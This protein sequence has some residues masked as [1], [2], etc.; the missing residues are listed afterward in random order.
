[1]AQLPSLPILKKSDILM[2]PEAFRHISMEP[3]LIQHTS[4]T[5]G[6]ILHVHRSKEE[7]AAIESFFSKSD[8]PT[9]KTTPVIISI[10]GSTTDAIQTPAP[11]VGQV[12]RLNL[13]DPTWRSRIQDVVRAP[14]EYVEGTHHARPAVIVGLESDLRVLTA[15]LRECSFDFS[16]ASISS[17]ITSGDVITRRLRRYYESTWRAPLFDQYGLSEIFGSCNQCGV[18]GHLH[19]DPHVIMEVVNPISSEPVSDGV[20]I[21]VFTTLAPFVQCQ[22]FI[23]YWSGDLVEISEVSCPVDLLGF[24]LLGR[25][26][27][28]V[29]LPG[30]TGSGIVLSAIEAYDALDDFSEIASSGMFKWLWEIKDHSQLGHLKFDLRMDSDRGSHTLVATI[31][32]RFT[33]HLYPEQSESLKFRI[34]DALCKRSGS[35]RESIQAGHMS[36]R[37]NL[38][39]PGSID[40]FMP[41]MVE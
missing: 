28:S 40:S 1:M 18:C 15:L 33:P 11:A 38:K 6:Q 37:I 4:G 27:K 36:L 30:L 5:S 31:E 14:W 41:D 25:L 24:R 8:E 26:Y 16:S 12:F 34:R 20:G 9:D 10:L 35:L 2:R 39:P 23:R 3:H 17:L 13:R 21:A 29:S 7:L 19:P 32:T 22:P